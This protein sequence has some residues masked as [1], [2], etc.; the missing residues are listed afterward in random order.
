MG[1][2]VKR[3]TLKIRLLT[4]DDPAAAYSWIVFLL[5]M[6]GG[7]HAMGVYGLGT[8]TVVVDIARG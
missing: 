7:T 1:F 4:A 6:S 5:A 8:A 3:P 2:H